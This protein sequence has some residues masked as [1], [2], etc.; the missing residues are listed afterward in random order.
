M[1]E[2]LTAQNVS[3][4]AP[5][6]AAFM[7]RRRDG[8]V[9]LLLAAFV[10]ICLLAGVASAQQRDPG[11]GLPIPG[12]KK[13]AFGKKPD[14]FGGKPKIDSAQPLYI[15]TDRL[16]YDDKTNRVIAEGNVEIYYNNY[17]LTA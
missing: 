17:I 9:W 5:G 4:H 11:M 6:R 3:E 13:S 15:Q 14:F 7:R 2:A 12:G 8:G 1:R 16:I 10:A